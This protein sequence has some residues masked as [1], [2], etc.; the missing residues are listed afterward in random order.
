M[1]QDDIMSPVGDCRQCQPD[2]PITVVHFLGH[3]LGTIMY[4]LCCRTVSGG[5]D[6]IFCLE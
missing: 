4:H 5:G 3:F 1:H 6:L 2:R